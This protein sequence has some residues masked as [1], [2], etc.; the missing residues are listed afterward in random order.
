MCCTRLFAL[1]PA[2]C[3]LPFDT[4]GLA[5]ISVWLVVFLSVAVQMTW[6]EIADA[7]VPTL[8]I[9]NDVINGRRHWVRELQV[10]IN[11]KATAVANVVIR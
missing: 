1:P 6:P 8:G 7:V 10:Q 5:Y 11:R 3:E 9:G 4:P 2:Q